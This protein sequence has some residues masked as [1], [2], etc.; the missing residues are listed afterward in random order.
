MKLDWGSMK[1][2]RKIVFPFVPVYY[3]ITRLRNVL[4]DKGIKSSVS[5]DFPVICVGNLSVGGT[6]KTPMI[7]YLIN[8]LKNDYLVATLS[9][10]YKR[11][12]E[13]FQLGDEQS[14]VETLG[15]EPFQF[16]NKFGDDILVAVD[17]DR[18]N[19][20]KQLKVLD[21]EPQ[22][23]LLDDAY[24]HRKVKAGFNI[25]L[26]AYSNLYTKDWMLPT[27][28]LREPRQGAKR[29]NIIVITKC[30]DDLSVSRKQRIIKAI[31]PESYQEVFFSS[32][33]YDSNIYSSDETKTLESLN[34]FTLVTGIANA[35]TLVNYL[36]VKNLNFDHL[37][38]D[39][40]HNFTDQEILLL[41]TKSLI[42][43]TEKD[44]MRL[45]QYDVLKEKLYYLPIKT[46]IDKP[47]VFNRL[48]LD[49]VKS[50]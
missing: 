35:N 32:I 4:Y 49:F 6:G 8:L 2:I 40:H 20:I 22:V 15:D 46:K 24:Q 9:R 30:P 45:K 41:S 21:P 47:E 29:A 33:D 38:F 16:Y 11:K 48:V 43:T 1:L 27:G 18:R 28:N 44:F 19:G 34:E 36:K 12:T 10:G 50:N 5:Y 17:A 26:S 7:E 37:N 39:D 42:L 23:I 31:A 13:G 14:I 25:L 3:L